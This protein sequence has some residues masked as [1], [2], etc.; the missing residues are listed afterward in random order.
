MNRYRTLVIGIAIG[1]AFG[2]VFLW[3][4]MGGHAAND[5]RARHDHGGHAMIHY[6]PLE[7]DEGQPIPTLQLSATL[8][9][10]EGWNLHL[11]TTHFTFTPEKISGGNFANEGH[12]HLYVDGAKYGR[13]YGPW[14]HLPPLTAG[15]HALRVTLNAN[16]HQPWAVNGQVVEDSVIIEQP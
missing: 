7:L 4:A 12:A 1:F 13:I 11:E 16:S 10:T 9:P 6:Q 5:A 15:P 3:E 14:Y 8:D 2:V